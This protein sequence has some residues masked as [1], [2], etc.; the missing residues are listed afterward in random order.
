MRKTCMVKGLCGMAALMMVCFLTACDDSESEPE[1]VIGKSTTVIDETMTVDEAGVISGGT[2][3]T[4]NGEGNA[5]GTAQLMVP[6]GAVATLLDGTY[7]AAGTVKT[8]L[9][10]SDWDS[11]PTFVDSDFTVEENPY[12]NP[13]EVTTGGFAEV[14]LEDSAGS[15]IRMFNQN[16]QITIDVTNPD[17]SEGEQVEIWRYDEETGWTAHAPEVNVYD[18]DG[19][20]V[21][22][23]TMHTTYYVIVA[24]T[25]PVTTGSGGTTI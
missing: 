25:D 5:T 4:A 21:T 12:G 14:Y 10:V 6:A 1:P 2:V 16:L 3:D 13:T 7:P 18:D 11:E 17:I 22:F 24:D 8:V 9:I 23:N 19:L 20:K 15:K